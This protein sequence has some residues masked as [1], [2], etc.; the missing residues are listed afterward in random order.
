VGY[1]VG[2]YGLIVSPQQNHGSV[3][4]H[5]TTNQQVVPWTV[6][7]AGSGILLRR[8]G[9]RV[10]RNSPRPQSDLQIIRDQFPG[11]DFGC[12]MVLAVT[13]R[14]VRRYLDWHGSGDMAWDVTRLP[15]IT[16]IQGPLGG[17]NARRPGLA[18]G[19]SSALP[20]FSRT[21]I[22][23][24]AEPSCARCNFSRPYRAIFGR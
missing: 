14:R 20:V 4:F 6:R 22:R 2:F 21:E 5:Q 17:R 19:Y 1:F 11:L 7:L 18:S 3:R 12:H 15:G 9:V 8:Y 24:Q 13:F 10:D 16:E 23:R